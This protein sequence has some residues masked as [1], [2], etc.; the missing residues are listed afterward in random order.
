MLALVVIIDNFMYQNFVTKYFFGIVSCETWT[1]LFVSQTFQYGIN[2]PN[3][4]PLGCSPDFSYQVQTA[5]TKSESNTQ[6]MTKNMRRRL[7]IRVRIL[8]PNT[9]ILSSGGISQNLYY[10]SSSDM[11]T[12]RELLW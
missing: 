1:E 12:K 9:L 7:R 2:Y 6:L 5:T 11:P 3:I 4:R 8:R 10:T